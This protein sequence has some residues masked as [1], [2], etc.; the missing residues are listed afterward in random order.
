MLFFFPWEGLGKKKP[1]CSWPKGIRQPCWRQLLEHPRTAPAC[2]LPSLRRLL[3][4]AALPRLGCA[5]G[6]GC[7]CP[8]CSGEGLEAG[9]GGLCGGVCVCT[10]CVPQ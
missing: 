7:M 5:K 6:W 10:A 9:R 8:C 2:L 1:G 4:A 3:G